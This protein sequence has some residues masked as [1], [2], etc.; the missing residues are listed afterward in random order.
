MIRV[1]SFTPPDKRFSVIAGGMLIATAFMAGTVAGLLAAGAGAPL[2]LLA[3]LCVQV[4]AAVFHVRPVIR[5]IS[6]HDSV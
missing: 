5:W 6:D 1:A 4:C 2:P 3:V